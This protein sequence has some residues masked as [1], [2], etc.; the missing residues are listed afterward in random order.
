[1]TG[2][3]ERLEHFGRV[4][5]IDALREQEVRY[6]RVPGVRLG[7]RTFCLQARLE[8]FGH[9]LLVDGV[10]L[11]ELRLELLAQRAGL[12]KLRVVCYCCTIRKWPTR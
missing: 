11:L 3:S 2:L 7:Q 5:Q 8:M 10:A 12:R 9:R 6:L 4:L 1:M